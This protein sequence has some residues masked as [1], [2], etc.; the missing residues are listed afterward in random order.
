MKK[1]NVVVWLHMHQPDYFD[2]VSK[3][4]YLPWVRRHALSGYYPV[5]KLLSTY[6]ARINI[7]F[8]GILIKQISDYAENNVNEYYKALEEKDAKSLTESEINFII[9]H[10]LIPL[11][12][13]N[14]ARFKELLS[15]KERREKFSTDEI[16]DTQVL[17]S[18]SAFSPLIEDVKALKAKDRNFTEQDKQLIKQTENKII[19]SLIGMYKN[20]YESGQI[21]LTITPFYHPIL[22]LLID[23]NSAKESKED[24]IL[25]YGRF[26]HSEDA[27]KQIKTAIEIFENTF[28]KKPQ[29]MWPAEGSISNEAVEL[30][31]G[32]GIEWIG[33]DE[34]VLRMS[35]TNGPPDSSVW[36]ARGMKILFRD[37]TLSDKIGFVY[38][39]MQ[40]ADAADDFYNAV[41]SA[42]K[43]KVVI[44]DGENP[45][46]FYPNSGIDFLKAW[47]SK[48]EEITV[49][50]SDAEAEGE[51]ESIHPG[52]WINGYFD[53]WIGHKES[54]IA[55][56]YLI[57]ARKKLGSED[58]L[59]EL[60]IAEGS[61]TFWWFSDFHKKEVDFS[62]DYLFRMH[63]IS[64][65][66]LQNEKVPPYL[67][68]PIK[69][70]K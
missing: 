11:P 67:N 64:A 57:N 34:A 35:K 23:S 70:V 26:M 16:R 8:S 21:E 59:K 51:M 22:P 58:A 47:F 46:E 63:L 5:A 13:A 14:S 20:L 68:Y 17:F 48:I 60:Y 7:N 66:K 31:K 9:R 33:T 54:N 44:L 15:K 2:P 6:P 19:G 18:L 32:N 43:T 40:P 30:I 49:S 69:E 52:S 36:N 55:W 10:F 37:H 62:F 4:Q 3:T 56:D 24:S 53:T 38:N 42:E 28:G 65:Y 25:P 61:D 12:N 50:G 1:N 29:G 27:S 41:Q 39:K 45:W